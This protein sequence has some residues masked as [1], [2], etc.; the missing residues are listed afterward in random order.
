M[1]TVVNTL[2]GIYGCTDIILGRAKITICGKM[3]LNVRKEFLGV[4]LQVLVGVTIDI[5][6]TSA[7]TSGV[8]GGFL[9]WLEQLIVKTREEF[10]VGLQGV[11]RM[12]NA[13]CPT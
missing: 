7:K 9:H 13:M 1:L 2:N 10:F 8:A 5:V 4:Y 12:R 6:P 3:L 11:E